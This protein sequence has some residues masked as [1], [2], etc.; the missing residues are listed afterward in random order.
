LGRYGIDLP[1][2]KAVAEAAIGPAGTRY[3][4]VLATAKDAEY[5]PALDAYLAAGQWHDLDV[6]LTPPRFDADGRKLANAR[7]ER[8]LLNDVLLHEGLELAGPCLGAPL[9]TLPEAGTGPL[10]ISGTRGACALRQIRVRPVQPADEAG[11]VPLFNGQDLGGWRLGTAS[12]ADPTPLP[13]GTTFTAPDEDAAE[14]T[15]WSV[16][17]GVL[18]GRGPA[19][20]L[21]SPRGDFRDLEVRASLRVSH[22]GNSGLYFRTTFGPGW[23]AGYEA[24]VNSS[25]PDPQKTGSLYALAPVTTSLVGPGTWFDYHVRC[26]DEPAGTHVT[27]RVNGVVITD[28][29]D[30]ERRHAAGHIALQQHDPGSVVQYR[31]VEVREAR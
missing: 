30:A 17:N 21:F 7:I 4:A 27:I 15:G 28:F 16:E 6:F 20:H 3:G 26:V 12:S 29:I 2:R 11:W 10:V 24:Q 9:A 14:T 23:P 5:P 31:R 1:D 19:T 13:A 25:S 22:E 18:F 8:V